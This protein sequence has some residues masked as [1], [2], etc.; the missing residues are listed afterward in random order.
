MKLTKT[1]QEEYET[2]SANEIKK[3]IIH[4]TE[5]DKIIFAYKEW[6]DTIFKNQYT[7]Q[8]YH[9]HMCTKANNLILNIKSYS[10]EDI[11]SFSCLLEN[12]ENQAKTN[13]FRVE[14]GFTSS[15][16][17]LSSLIKNHYERNPTNNSYILLLDHLS[18]KLDGIGYDTRNTKIN[19][20]GSVG[21]F[22][23]IS[24]F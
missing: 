24:I 19:V 23:C 18:K 17:F 8:G 11:T 6:L 14:M 10:Q 15:G 20:Q 3:N 22:F 5:L 4:T 9:D 7:L 1:I 13:L 21:N 2:V 12:F 16:I